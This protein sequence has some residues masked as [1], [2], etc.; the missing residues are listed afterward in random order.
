MP[1]QMR[2]NAS[3]NVGFTLIELLVVIAIIAIIAA[4]LLPV[5]GGA[6]AKAQRAACVNDLRQI[7]LGVRMYSDDSHDAS[8]SSGPAGLPLLKIDS[9]YLGYKALMK[10]YVGLKGASSPQDKL[11]ACPADIFN[12]NQLFDH[13]AFPLQFV[14]KSL[15]DESNFDYSSYTFNGGDNVAREFGGTNAT[16]P[17]LT[18]VK[19]SSVKHPDRTILLAE[20]SAFFPYSWH[21]PSTHGDADPSGLMYNDSRNVVSFVDGHVSYIKMY[22]RSRVGPFLPNPPANYGYQWSPD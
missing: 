17:G 5:F 3:G 14:R 18:G 21:D 12:I 13:S 16:V 11:F 8:P 19:L 20:T 9:L 10:N 6:K 22:F 7:G 15:H 4:L 1:T 2:S